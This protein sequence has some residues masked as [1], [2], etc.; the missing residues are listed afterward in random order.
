MNKR[1]KT[2]ILALLI[3]LVA[4]SVVACNDGTTEEDGNNVVDDPTVDQV[5]PVNKSVV[6]ENIRNGLVNAEAAVSGMTEG[7]RNVTSE[8]LYNAGG[9]NTGIRYEANYAI[10]R[11]VDSEI[12]LSVHNY[13][14]A[15]DVLFI[16]YDSQSLYYSIGGL[17]GKFENF[18]LNSAFDTFFT[19]ITALDMQQVFY[20]ED[21]ADDIES[22]STMAESANIT[23]V[24][25]E[26][27]VGGVAV[28]GETITVTDI[29]LDRIRNTVNDF[30][31]NV[32][33][34]IGTSVDALTDEFL[35]F[36][37]SDMIS[38]Q[39]GQFTAT[40]FMTVNDIV[41][42]NYI[43]RGF[44]ITFGG[45]QNNVITED[46]DYT[47]TVSYSRADER[48][49]FDIPASVNPDNNND[50]VNDNA[51][52]T[53]M[54]GNLKL[55]FTDAEFT[56]DFRSYI[57][58]EDN[59]KNL[60]AFN[61]YREEGVYDQNGNPTTEKERMFGIYMAAG[62]IY[63]DAEG[64]IDNYLRSHSVSEGGNVIYGDYLMDFES[65]GLPK[66]TIGTEDDPVDL[67]GAINSVLQQA[68]SMLSA[69]MDGFLGG[70]MSPSEDEGD[71]G[72]TSDN[73]EQVDWNT[74]FSKIE[75]EIVEYDSADY[76]NKD[77]YIFRV[78]IDSEFLEAVFGEDISTIIND[79]AASMGFDRA[80]VEK[81]TEMGLFDGLK[82]VVE[83][84]KHLG[85]V[86]LMLMNG[87]DPEPLCDLKLYE[88]VAGGNDVDN[89]GN[90]IIETPLDRPD[91]LVR[92]EELTLPEHFGAHF[93]A[94]ITFDNDT[95]ISSFLGIMT[96]DITGTNTPFVLL[97]GN[98][99]I[100]TGS[101]W[102]TAAGLFFDLSIGY[103]NRATSVEEN[104]DPILLGRM[105]L[106]GDDA[107]YAYVYLNIPGKEE[108]RYR[109]T[110]SSVTGSVSDLTD[111]EFDYD[112]LIDLLY[113]ILG[114]STVSLEGS[115][116]GV[117]LQSTESDTLLNDFFESEF[118]AK[119]N[120]S[121]FF[122]ELTF[123]YDPD[124]YPVPT[125]TILD[126]KGNELSADGVVSF[127]NIYKAKWLN[128]AKVTIGSA[129]Y[130]MSISYTP[131]SIAITP[132]RVEY[133]PV[134][135]LM[136]ANVGYI[137]RLNEADGGK[138]VQIPADG[139]DYY[140]QIDPTKV[141]PFPER[142]PVVYTDGTRGYKP[143]AIVDDA[144]N[145]IPITNETI[146]Q[147]IDGVPAAYYTLII[148]EGSVVETEYRI[149]LEVLPGVLTGYTEN[150]N[151]IPI[152]ASVTIDPLE[153]GA[154]VR[155]DPD[156]DPLRYDA[157]GRT[158]ITLRFG[159]A[160]GLS[161]EVTVENSEL[162]WD[163]SKLKVTFSAADWVFYGKYQGTVD[164]AVA[165][166]VEPKIDPEIRIMGEVRGEYTVDSLRTETYTIPV[167]T[168][169]DNEVR[170]YFASDHYRIVGNEADY[171]EMFG[172]LP[173]DD[174]FD[175]FYEM[176]L[177]WSFGMATLTPLNGTTQ[178]LDDGRTG[179]TT[180]EFGYAGS[181]G[182]QTITLT[183]TC[184]AR[185][186]GLR[187]GGAAYD[188]ANRQ[189]GAQIN[190][191]SFNY[192]GDPDSEVFSYN[193][194][195]DSVVLPSTVYINAVYREGGVERLIGYPVTWIAEE[196]VVNAD[197][198]VTARVGAE[199]YYVVTGRIGDGDT[200]GAPTIDLN[201]LIC[202]ES[203]DYDSLIFH[204]G[205][206]TVDDD[207]YVTEMNPYEL[208]TGVD[209]NGETFMRLPTSVE[210]FFAPE[211]GIPATTYAT[212][213]YFVRALNG[214]TA[215]TDY[216]AIDEAAAVAAGRIYADNFIVSPDG[217]TFV[218]ATETAED[219][220]ILS[221]Y[222]EITVAFKPVSVIDDAIYGLDDDG[223]I[224]TYSPESKQL[225]DRLIAATA[226][227]Y[228]DRAGIGFDASTDVSEV[229]VRWNSDELAAFIAAM[230]SPA[231]G[232]D[233]RL[234]AT[235]Y[236]GTLL[237][238][239]ISCLF[240]IPE[241]QV[242]SLGFANHNPEVTV[243]TAIDGSYVD[244]QL[245]VQRIYALT[246][247]AGFATPY[248]YI[249]YLL[250]D[251]DF[252]VG[253]MPYKAEAEYTIDE[254]LFNAAA[255]QRPGADYPGATAAGGII[256]IPVTV[257]NLYG[258]GSCK[259]VLTLRVV[260]HD[261]EIPPGEQT[262]TEQLETYSQAGAPLYAGGYTLPNES[263]VTFAYKES[264][265]SDNYV[266]YEVSI[267]G[268]N[269]I[270][271]NSYT[272]DQGVEWI[273]GGDQ[274][275]V[276]PSGLMSFDG[277]T[278]IVLST[279]LPDGFTPLGRQITVRPKLL[280][281]DGVTYRYNAA[282]TAEN[283]FAVQS[284]YINIPNIF[285]VYHL[286][287]DNFVSL[288]PTVIQPQTTTVFTTA[289]PTIDFAV[290]GWT[291]AETFATNGTF[292]SAKLRQ[293]LTSGGYEGLLATSEII[294]YNGEI[295]TVELGIRVTALT[296]P[297]IVTS[298][299]EDA[300]IVDPATNLQR[301]ILDPYGSYSNVEG[302]FP[303]P[304]RPTLSFNGGSVVHTFTQNLIYQ[305]AA[306]PGT[307]V[308]NI[309]YNAYDN[310]VQTYTV[311][312]PDG[313]TFRFEV[314]FID[315]RL[316]ENSYIEY[317]TTANSGAQSAIFR[318]I[319]YI[320][321][322]DTSTY[323]LPGYATFVFDTDASPLENYP[324]G[325]WTKHKGADGVFNGGRYNG[326]IHPGEY[327]FS[328]SLPRRGDT[329]GQVFYLT[330]Y[331][332]ER[333]Y[334]GEDLYEFVFDGKEGRPDPFTALV[335]DMQP[336]FDLTNK[337][338]DVYADYYKAG[339][340]PVTVD[341]MWYKN[342]VSDGNVLTDNDL[343]ILG[344]YELRLVGVVGHGTGSARSAGTNV[345][346][347]V[348]A[349]KISFETVGRVGPEGNF[350]STGVD[351]IFA[352]NPFTFECME[353]Q[354]YVRFR[355]L[356][357]STA[358]RVEYIDVLFTEE[359]AVEDGAGAKDIAAVIEWDEQWYEDIE[360]AEADAQQTYSITLIN[361]NKANGSIVPE[362]TYRLITRQISI[363]ELDLGYGQ[364]GTQELQLVI[365]P[366]N[367]VI[368]ER[369]EAFGRVT[370]TSGAGEGELRSVGEVAITW[371][372]LADG[373]LISDC[374]LGGGTRMFT[375]H[376]VTTEGYVQQEAEFSV[377]VTYLNR[378]PTSFATAIGNYS[379]APL[380]GGYY[381]LMTN[382]ASGVN[383]FFRIDP[384]NQ[385]LFI[386]DLAYANTFYMSM[387]NA[388]YLTSRYVLPDSLRVQ[389]ANDYA[390]GSI[391]A[392]GL[393]KLGA[394][395]ELYDI[396]WLIERDCDADTPD[397]YRDIT[398]AGTDVLGGITAKPRRFMIRYTSVDESGVVR[399]HTAGPFD[400]F[401]NDSQLGIAY[402]LQLETLDRQVT[403]TSIST[404]FST[405]EGL[406][407]QRAFDEYY[408]DPYDISFPDSISVTFGT[409]SGTYTRNYTGIVWSYDEAYMEDPSV[410]TGLEDG[411][412]LPENSIL[413]RVE[414]FMDVYGTTLMVSFPIR[415]RHIAETTVETETGPTTVPMS[416]GT[417]YVLQGIPMAEQLPDKLY[418]RFEYEDGDEI[419][420]VPLQFTETAV[421]QLSTDVA[422]TVYSNVEGQLGINKGNIRFTIIVVDP[423]LYSVESR[424]DGTE[425][426]YYDGAFVYDVLPIAV[427]INGAYLPGPEQQILPDKVVID[428]GVYWDIRSI[429]YF[430]SGQNPYAV[431][432]AGYRFTSS[433][434]ND[435]IFGDIEGSNQLSISFEVPISTYVY[436][437]VQDTEAVLRGV[438]YMEGV[439]YVS[440]PLGTRLT[441][442]VL[443]KAS[444]REIIPLWN[445]TGVNQNRA[446][447]YYAE[448][449]YVN[450]YNETLTGTLRIIIQP[451]EFSADQMEFVPIL[452]EETIDFLNHAYMDGELNIDDYIEFSETFLREDGTSGLPEG[453]TVTYSINGGVTWQTVQPVNVGTYLVRITIDDYNYT[454]SLTF[455]KTI[456][457]RNVYLA[458][459]IYFEDPDGT[460][461]NDRWVYDYDGAGH[462]P[463][464]A[465]VPTG[466]ARQIMF[467]EYDPA[468][469]NAGHN[470][471]SATLPRIAGEYLMRVVFDAE[472]ANY[473]I[474]GSTVEFYVR[475]LINPAEIDP[476]SVFIVEQLEYN[477]VERDAVISGL[478]SGVA[479]VIYT[480]TDFNGAPLPAGTRPRNVGTYNVHVQINGGNNYYSYQ[481]SGSFDIVPREI[482]ISI[483][484]IRSE[485]LSD[486]LP[487]DSALRI[488]YAK[489]QS[490][491][492]LVGDELAMVR[493][494]EGSPVG[495]VGTMFSVIFPGV[496][497]MPIIN[498]VATDLDSLFM[499]DE[500]ELDM[501]GDWTNDN[502]VYS[503]IQEQEIN[504]ADG[505][506]GAYY[507]GI[508]EIAAVLQGS[509]VI[510]D[511][512]ML[513][514][515]IG[516]L[517]PGATARWYLMPGN[518][519]TISIDVNA[520]VSIIG[521]YEFVDGVP[522]IAV[523]FNKI[524]VNRGT[525]MLD[526]LNF[527]AA[528]NRENVYIG[529]EATVTVRR[530][531]FIYT[532]QQKLSGSTAIY[533]ADGSST[534]LSLS[535]ITVSGYSTAVAADSGNVVIADSEFRSNIT[536]VNVL[537][538][539]VN[540]TDTKFI[541]NVLGLSIGASGVT[542]QLS[543]CE[544][545]YNET[546]IETYV[547]LRNDYAAQNAFVQ[548]TVN[549]VA[550]YQTE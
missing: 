534:P 92:Y 108:M 273:R 377:N 59:M 68:M 173:D 198:T 115:T 279:T 51:G 104:P 402:Q 486:I 80:I 217:G 29:N 24:P 35:G 58:L 513:Q 75:S 536:A 188:V 160:A 454:G 418:Y 11:D 355:D 95:D 66:A 372:A 257:D 276:I 10:G 384:T 336:E 170:I 550:K 117:T 339:L 90:L 186:V 101:A 440:I 417:I 315:R 398:L 317:T 541:S 137:M 385:N 25:T 492:G 112:S 120:V 79:F 259:Q 150:V 549:V 545:R 495:Y 72:D 205:T 401:A 69:G 462:A 295:Q 220:N 192:T 195:S 85:E 321:P 46:N 178:P 324:T 305:N 203:G 84:Q 411:E 100:L 15:E 444:S 14:T 280:T 403:S 202:N 307:Q 481:M 489:D 149:S 249:A 42:D 421:G 284:G 145:Y 110:E 332:L 306:K 223:E 210:L 180:A 201:M 329:D 304:L 397:R 343:N 41:D 274:V 530:S 142:V 544:F 129:E 98:R 450:V 467:A 281:S 13:Q 453:Y 135:L 496:S 86:R 362:V 368:P 244:Y 71:T 239:E 282:A 234:S 351:N 334:D 18:R 349:P 480:Y 227:D 121:F 216:G 55:P 539:S 382:S 88:S 141:T 316:T 241:K 413:H 22:L 298:S 168:D 263:T 45:D 93:S 262:L 392:Q 39:V 162:G 272:D 516:R 247:G 187:Y 447:T 511:A 155:Q 518:Y 472:Q 224:D 283:G 533:A 296:A 464:V 520:N 157:D 514:D 455:E 347:T 49:E 144:G 328:A 461:M 240:D 152:V 301:L 405:S 459:N 228:I 209:E 500:Y 266:N 443:P 163:I 4:L 191:A 542:P 414:A 477:G 323:V 488:L 389:F 340:T 291:P 424:D 258:I 237:E 47:F 61:V 445:T 308:F 132:G 211:S 540:V 416:G 365:D 6:F 213:W 408:I 388:T 5:T 270:A 197:G 406:Y 161:R 425:D 64:L 190:I 111:T 214:A 312:L 399:E 103:Y 222:I 3:A 243:L 394:T 238:A 335:S 420:G 331:V 359:G 106:S 48:Q 471:S 502:Y 344:D 528:A 99:L 139:Y 522:Q 119:A 546:A 57:D 396:D 303:I 250:S 501:I 352:F 43:N 28:A 452:G 118:T 456:T 235:V 532:G 363:D 442:D 297:T 548:N 391:G 358:E 252:T 490:M 30:L 52:E 236:E 179:T 345:D 62:V 475:I 34:L 311:T 337:Q 206:V 70:L 333:D 134:S 289:Y 378:V 17:R 50:Y 212:N 196:G 105:T 126:L 458:E 427:T 253:D 286:L 373:T 60:I 165:V 354:F 94:E 419:A 23:L 127:D 426:S 215:G 1:L 147:Y 19:A 451:L 350:V 267:A 290:N 353:A 153:Y 148:G 91:E 31:E 503:F 133:Y 246:D 138:I 156:Y 125:V 386:T 432:H 124:E 493:A 448:Y 183:V 248:E 407:Y 484:R 387:D 8:Y 525:V 78:T 242:T 390:A 268:L 438:Q 21:F 543:G 300:G 376:V 325:T 409:G 302:S 171:I 229:E 505:E 294:G 313:V 473:N 381:T 288:I 287:D 519:D 436:T 515:F 123:G 7:T 319:Y 521:S 379:T 261:S 193:P 189:A 299:L 265:L 277:G 457:P 27:T 430:T 526:I 370:G 176:N 320:D 56:V 140:W 415:H 226:N 524:T 167:T 2:L 374:P 446:G 231:G 393:N 346:G 219:E 177:N 245:T 254:D 174:Y 478:P 38:L 466:L 510:K 517:T 109:L 285:A 37:F 410:V 9:V 44:D 504:V 208:L 437:S 207:R 330:V 309:E 184:P 20:S 73:T 96:G 479:S 361:R 460:Y 371:E 232:A 230:Q 509:M 81:I 182:T 74:I 476:D 494:E 271:T 292:D 380:E 264:A 164:I 482:L 487:Y 146:G 83:Y 434:D 87:D 428:E 233:V 369:A 465:G 485:Y 97:N 40:K 278:T 136:G 67:T 360:N 53:Y 326:G 497:V 431:I 218:F 221:Q 498:G 423:K 77:A 172:A 54:T 131:E 114:A 433:T 200:D 293:A 512:E 166:S 537:K 531:T 181:I 318:D 65:M 422:G 154:A 256:T 89:D 348:K 130:Y 441:A 76:R 439:P 491:P 225:L 169:P 468:L 314:G 107:E 529:N 32:Y 185:E 338:S 260:F 204:G 341:I 16:Y 366:M 547:P 400:Y 342:S 26:S 375:M 435:R 175:G 508:Y 269:W 158:S 470:F 159:G 251:I 36:K 310:A 128:E 499:V 506:V 356:D 255:Y 275:T 33:E 527:R 367:P 538:G 395:L 102:E 63:F 449:S 523:N 12:M 507:N 383:Y 535:E 122:D 113:A 364:A 199:T 404:A 469:S 82:L 463:T 151:G 357:A 116:L 322:Y 474:V 483:G 194:Y 327:V 412:P 143:Y 429:E